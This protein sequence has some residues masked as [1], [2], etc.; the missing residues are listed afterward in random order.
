M[1]KAPLRNEKGQSIIIIALIL[2]VLVALIALVIDVGNSY[3]Q[4]RIVQAA[5][6]A[7]S[8]AAAGEL[9]EE[10]GTYASIISIGKEFVGKN[11]ADPTSV[12]IW[13]TDAEGHKLHE[14][15]IT[16]SSNPPPDR[17]D[18]VRVGGV[19]LTAGKD[20]RAFFAG[21]VGR[22]L[23]QASALSISVV[24]RGAC[25]IDDCDV[26]L[27][28]IAVKQE[29]FAP[30]DGKIVPNKIYRLWDKD[31]ATYGNF[32]WLTWDGDPSQTT[33]V[34]NMNDTSRSGPWAVGDEIPGSSG[35]Q[36]SSAARAAMNA[37]LDRNQDD[38]PSQVYL[39]IYDYTTGS[40]NNLSYHI[41]GFGIFWLTDYNFHGSDKWI[42]G[43]FVEGEIPCTR[44]YGCLDLGT[45]GVKQRTPLSVERAVVGT[46]SVAKLIP[47]KRGS[48]DGARPPVDM[49]NVMDVSGSMSYYW[50]GGNLREMKLDTAK[51]VLAGDGT[52]PEGGFKRVGNRY[53]VCSTDPDDPDYDEDCT[54]CSSDPS[55][56]N[57]WFDNVTHKKQ[58]DVC[59][60]GINN[61]L[62]PSQDQVGLAIYPRYGNGAYKTNPSYRSNCGSWHN[63]W[64]Y[65]K[66][67][68]NLT[69]DIQAV[70]DEVD[71]MSANGGTPMADGTRAG[72][73]ALFDPQFHDPSKSVPV[74]I[75]ATDG[76]CNATL[77]GRWTG[78]GGTNP[79][80][81]GG[82][83]A[84]A[85]IQSV[86]QANMAK[87]EGAIIF[88]IAI[89]DDFG[90]DI[91]KNMATAPA[92]DTD[93]YDG[94]DDAHFFQASDP[95]GLAAIYDRIAK[96]VENIGNECILKQSPELA[97]RSRVQLW[98]NGQLAQDEDGQ[99]LETIA[100]KSGSFVFTKVPAGT[101]E[102]RA[103]WTDEN[104]IVYDVQTESL[105][106]QEMEDPA[107][108]TVEVPE[109]TAM[110]YKD[111]YLKTN[112]VP[113]C[114]D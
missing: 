28:P 102:I 108:A 12:Q 34:A 96:R 75:V 31:N 71:R 11:G 98:K 69:A 99:A 16:P 24:S 62:D 65:G 38:R 20:F 49:M 21:V 29:L 87:Q 85:E 55:D 111:I 106:G 3:A 35:V 89:G 113:A 4:K 2:V 1:W 92:E 23:L 79:S 8:L 5:V 91:L 80:G 66:L 114:D 101:Y 60:K 51:R 10:S 105:G 76:M 64:Y 109:G 47:E 30:D 97:G 103:T 18:G 73:E 94:K 110:L 74:L 56:P 86:D 19:Y 107:Y 53:E 72:R 81:M 15:P 46:V 45:Q 61:Y 6:D 37:R 95:K 100:T 54:P 57:T 27:F 25:G 77:D 40:G 70:N 67:M 68:Q 112:N 58:L 42:E 84:L 39:P 32:G 22:N 59:M 17:I 90:G 41:V 44:D 14:D 63:K 7:A 33:L 13:L 52:G 78:Y 83:N 88:T 36:N 9:I 93:P 50:G 82:C 48:A 104:G 26:G 43:Y